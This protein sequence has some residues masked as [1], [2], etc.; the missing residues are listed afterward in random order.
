MAKVGVL[1][2]LGGEE[3]SGGLPAVIGVSISGEPDVVDDRGN[4]DGCEVADDE[5]KEV[6]A[7][8]VVERNPPMRRMTTFAHQVIKMLKA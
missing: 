1:G 3:G 8:L 4:S 7:R 5:A 6:G 2:K